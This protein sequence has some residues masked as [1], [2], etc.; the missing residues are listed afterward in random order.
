MGDFKEASGWMMAIGKEN[1]AYISKLTIYV[2]LLEASN[3]EAR[4]ISRH[5]LSEL[6]GRMLVRSVRYFMASKARTLTRTLRSLGV[7]ESCV[8]VVLPRIQTPFPF[9]ND[10]TFIEPISTEFEKRMIRW[11]SA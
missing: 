1:V 8:T 7:K 10:R 3:I 5:N 9:L 11:R 6:S 4:A 2:Q